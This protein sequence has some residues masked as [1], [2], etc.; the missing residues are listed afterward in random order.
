[1]VEIL[2]KLTDLL[3]EKNHQ[4]A[5]ELALQL[6]PKMPDNLYLLRLIADLYSALAH[7]TTSGEQNWAFEEEA[8]RWRERVVQAAPRIGWLWA[9]L[10]WDYELHLD[11]EQAHRAFREALKWDPCCVEALRGLASLWN[12]PENEG[13]RWI[14]HDEMI[15]CLK[16]VVE[17]EHRNPGPAIQ[18]LVHELQAIGQHEEARDYVVRA[19]LHFHSPDPGVIKEFEAI[20]TEGK[21]I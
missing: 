11:H 12:L 9:E 3:R 6:H 4:A 16:R 5:L 2:L 13:E 18:W 1:M 17:L 14:T 15:A 8:I 7:T 10:G 20:L 19:L 21:G